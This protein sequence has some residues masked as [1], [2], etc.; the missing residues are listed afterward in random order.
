MTNHV[1]TNNIKHLLG[2]L[3]MQGVTRFV[4]SPGSRTTPIALLV[5]EM[6]NLRDD[7]QV[8]VDV[9]ERSA[10]F[11]AL[12]MAKATG[13]PVAL[14]A[15]SGTA[16]AN[17]LPALVEATVSHVPLVV[18]TTDRPEELQAIGAPQT[19]NQT[20]LYGSYAKDFASLSMQDAHEDVTAYIDYRVQSLVATSIAA[21]A[22]VV[23]INLPLRKPLMPDLGENWPTIKG[24]FTGKTTT[25]M[26]AQQVA[27]IQNLL[28]SPK[29]AVLGGPSETSFFDGE[30]IKAFADKFAA[31]LWSDLLSDTRGLNGVI[32]GIDAMLEA[33]VVSDEHIPDV[34]VRFGGTPVSAKVIAWLAENDVQVIQ[35][36]ENFVGHDHSRQATLDV[37]V[38]ITTFNKQ[39]S[40]NDTR[41]D[42]FR[43]AWLQLS[44]RV[45]EAVAETAVNELKIPAGLTELSE[46]TPVFVAN[47]MPI[48]DMDNYYVPTNRVRILANRGANGIDGTVSTAAGVIAAT[49]RPGVLV[50]GDL[51][52]FH[53]MN[54]LMMA[55]QYQLDMT[56]FV[57]NNNGGGIFSFLPQAAAKDYFEEMFGTPLDLSVEKIAALYDAKYTLVDDAS[58]LQALLT[59]PMN[60][61]R[62][63]EWRSDREQNV[64]D[65]RALITKIQEAV[66]G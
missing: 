50:T 65:H 9:D 61:L 53:D 41:D 66:H 12:G 38:S 57:V 25:E 40:A 6:A 62:L 19:I 54:G 60:G 20:N 11:F 5:A 49:G 36:G 22:G 64:S 28:R 44:S 7:V 30:I 47:S 48:R 3:T 18:L 31:P 37:P 45:N 2:A 8:F 17:Y 33:G 21:P 58:E 32:N 27:A 4:V 39:L 10:G 15:T 56:I 16:T 23:Q 63:F 13:T 55:K 24:H 29:V 26:S 34:V 59:K 42:S 14:L 35:V 52:L 1:L 46:G 43:V 51:T